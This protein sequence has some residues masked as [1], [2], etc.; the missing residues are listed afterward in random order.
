MATFKIK[1]ATELWTKTGSRT[2]L[3]PSI[4][5]LLETGNQIWLKD[6]TLD[7]RIIVPRLDGIA[8]PEYYIN[9]CVEFAALEPYVPP[10][11]IFEMPPPPDEVQFRWKNAAGEV[12]I[13][14][15]Y[16]KKNVG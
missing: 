12:V 1:M 16:I 3:K 10:I 2:G 5:M 9:K 8:Y 7:C 14:Q 4:G 6:R 13:T 15:D 11:P